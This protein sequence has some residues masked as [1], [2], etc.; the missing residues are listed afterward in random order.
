MPQTASTYKLHRNVFYIMVRDED[1]IVSNVLA[2]FLG[3]ICGG[4]IFIALRY[5]TVTAAIHIV[6]L[7]YA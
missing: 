3:D 6:S 4:G 7:I 5:I 2:L 1:T